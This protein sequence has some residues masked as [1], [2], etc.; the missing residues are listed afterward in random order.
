MQNQD[1]NYRNKVNYKS[2]VKEVDP[3]ASPMAK[4]LKFCTLY[5]GSPGSDRGSGPAPLSSHTVEA[6]HIQSRGR[7]AQMLAQG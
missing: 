2:N 4:C 6:Y 1:L 3:G 5:L 7:L